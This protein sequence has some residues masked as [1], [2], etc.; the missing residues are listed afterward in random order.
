[1]HA[2]LFGVPRYSSLESRDE[3]VARS[4]MDEYLAD[5]RKFLSQKDQ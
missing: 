4:R 3:S 5:A 2:W 1:M